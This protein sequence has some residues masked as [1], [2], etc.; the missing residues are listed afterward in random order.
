MKINKEK[1]KQTLIKKALGYTLEETAYEYSADN[2]LIKRK[3]AE[4]YVPADLS[5]IKMLLE[6]IDTDEDLEKLNDE[7]LTKLRKKYLKELS[8]KT[9]S[10]G[11]RPHIAG[12]PNCRGGRPRPPEN[13][14]P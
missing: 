5:A 13:Q 14:K 6:T 8:R 12:V 7:E 9:S 1:I 4:K 2:T 3:V 10:R 11:G